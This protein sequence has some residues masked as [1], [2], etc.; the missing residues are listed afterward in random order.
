MCVVVISRGVCGVKLLSSTGFV[1][2]N[3]FVSMV[4]ADWSGICH[5]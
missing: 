1:S 4:T 3:S 5:L 2:V